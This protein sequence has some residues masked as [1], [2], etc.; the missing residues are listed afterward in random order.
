M[1]GLEVSRT[2]SQ[3]RQPYFE[4]DEMSVTNPAPAAISGDTWSVEGGIRSFTV[5]I[6]TEPVDNDLAGVIIIAS[7]TGDPEYDAEG[8][9]VFYKGPWQEYITVTT[10]ASNELLIPEQIYRVGIATYDQ[11]GSAVAN[12]DFG[13]TFKDVVTFKVATADIADDAVDTDQ[14]ADEAITDAKIASLTADK[15]DAGTITGST[16]RTAASGK[17]FVVSTTNN[18]AHFYGDRGDGTIDLLGQIGIDTAND[19]VICNM[20]SANNQNLSYLGQSTFERTAQFTNTSSGATS[21]GVL[22]ESTGNSSTTPVGVYGVVQRNTDPSGA[23]VGVY[24][25]IDGESSA[26]PPSGSNIRA[27]YGELVNGA[28]GYALYGSAA[29]GSFAIGAAGDSNLSG[30]VVYFKSYTVATLPSASQ[31]AGMI[32]V[33]D[34]TGGA[35]M[36]FSDGTNWRRVTDR[37]VVA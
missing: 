16:L 6:P 22:G 19:N 13:S 31:A 5:N 9:D 32:Y 34:E 23:C 4:D 8:S 37:A 30:G 3:Q 33:S 27:V 26:T 35:V 21:I 28:V 17:R 36:A 11:F 15:I 20:G 14:V 29:P 18:E 25:Q 1:F 12:V 7:T 24:G 10:D 2:K